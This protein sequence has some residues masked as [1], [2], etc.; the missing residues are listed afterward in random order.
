[1]TDAFDTSVLIIGAGP[2]GLTLACDLARR[3]VAHR[4]VERDPAPSRA[5]RAKAIQPRSLEV[6]DDLGAVEHVLRRGVAGLPVRFHEPSGAVVDK[7]PISVR[8]DEQFHTP[9]PDVLWLGQFDVE[10]ALRQRLGEL[11]GHVE[12]AAE[13]V[14]IEQDDDGVTATLSTPDGER[15]VRARFVVGADGGKSTTRKPAGLPLVGR[16]YEEQ[17]WYLGDV[18][19]PG[20]DRGHIHIWPS[21]HGMLGLTPLGDDLWQFQS[22]IPPGEH[23]G[24]PSLEFYQ[25][26]FDARAGKGAVALE[27]ASWLSVYQVNVRMVENYRN[28]RVLLAGDAAHVHP[29]AGGQGMNTGIQDAYNLGW[30]LASVLDGARIHLLDTYGAERIPVAR[31]VLETSAEKMT[32]TLAQAGRGAEDGLGSALAGIGDGALNSGLGIHYR[33][34]PLVHPG[35][36]ASGPVPG[37]RAPNV[38]GLRGEGFSGDL[39]DLMRGPHW[40][41]IAYEDT[42]PVIF[43]N[44]KPTHMHV[45]RIGST[46]DSAI[47]DGEGEF[48]RVYHPHPGELILIRTD[49]YLIARVPADREKDVIE[50]LAPFRSTGTRVRPY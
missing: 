16:T 50:H 43:D 35:G 38:G 44:A 30:K 3:G 46:S 2:T 22:P 4:I 33:T 49:G 1:M 7:P 34:S 8:A 5:T 13:V 36:P 14:G 48:Q 12:F 20:L 18:T 19:A 37:D 31:T 32:R 40:S 24:T 42:D 15:G 47:V 6:L 45:H 27:S 17:R 28:G 25:Q 29:P 21:E 9:Y 10:Q 41:L 26:L 39:F 11:G 23:A